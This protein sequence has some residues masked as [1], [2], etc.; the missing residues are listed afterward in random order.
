MRVERLW[1]S[2][3]LRYERGS[4]LLIA[5]NAYAIQEALLICRGYRGALTRVQ[6]YK[7]VAATAIVPLGKKRYVATDPNQRRPRGCLDL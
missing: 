6:L 2:W 3:L 7:S 5:R 4:V 1:K